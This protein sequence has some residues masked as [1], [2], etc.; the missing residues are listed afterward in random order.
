MSQTARRLLFLTAAF[1]LLVAGP[2]MAANVSANAS[3][4]QWNVPQA[5]GGVDL[6]V[7]GPGIAFSKSFAAGESPLFSVFSDDGS[8]LA[9]GQYNWQL[10]VRPA[11]SPSLR[12]EMDAS[13]LAGDDTYSVSLSETPTGSVS[14]GTFR[15]IGGIFVT[16]TDEVERGAEAPDARGVGTPAGRDQQILDDLIVNGGSLCVGQ[17]CVNGESFS[18]D[19]IRLKENN[20]RIHFQDTSNTASFPSV[21]WRIV[22]NDTTNGGSNYLAFEDAST[23]RIPFR[24]EAGA[25]VHSLYVEDGGRVGFGTSTP[26]VELHSVDGNTPTLRLEQDGSD[27][28]TPQTFD[29][30]ANEANFFIRDVTNGSKLSFRIRP[31]APESSIDIAGDGDVGMGTSAPAAALHV[32]RASTV[33]SAEVRIENATSGGSARLYV[34]SQDGVGA[35]RELGIFENDGFPRVVLDNT[36]TSG[37]GAANGRWFFG[38][39]GGDDFVISLDGTVNNEVIVNENGD[40][41]VRGDVT[42]N[43]MMLTSDRRLKTDIQ[44]LDSQ[45]I[46]A[47]LTDMPVATWRFRS[48]ATEALHLGPMAQDFYAAF[49]LGADER[50]ISP[51]DASGVALAA[52]QGLNQKLEA[53]QDRIDDLEARLAALEALLLAQAEADGQ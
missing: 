33:N 25:P 31:G 9:D 32:R 10:I 12:A 6:T 41:T 39:N 49:G 19:T 26:V 1:A 45:S 37:A 13:R 40:M 38:L 24:V 27:G 34:S 50:H 14:S 16:P 53:K 23:G 18:F 52:I 21:D 11:V 2:A 4:I 48:D 42:A 17:D 30:A 22:A 8:G 46:L 20:L 47:S 28:F 29:V 3:Q 15:V 43:G 51:L 7:T 5:N 35:A 36:S 44:P